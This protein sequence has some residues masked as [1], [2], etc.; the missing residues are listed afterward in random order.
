MIVEPMPKK[1]TG[2]LKSTTLAGQMQT[3]QSLESQRQLDKSNGKL[4]GNKS[5][6]IQGTTENEYYLYVHRGLFKKQGRTYT[7]VINERDHKEEYR[8]TGKKLNLP[9]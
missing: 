6:E 1:Q 3:E 2:R 8:L 5:A 9:L 4:V 7:S